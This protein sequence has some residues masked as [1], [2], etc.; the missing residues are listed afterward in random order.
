MICYV[1]MG[2]ACAPFTFVA[3]GFCRSRQVTSGTATVAKLRCCFHPWFASSFVYELFCYI[4]HKLAESLSGA[5][6]ARCICSPICRT[7]PS[8][9]ART[10]PS[11][12]HTESLQTLSSPGA[13]PP[14][15][16][17]VHTGF[18]QNCETSRP[19]KCLKNL[20]RIHRQSPD[21][22]PSARSACRMYQERIPYGA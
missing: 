3:S 7:V 17:S 13:A 9:V 8:T 15:I 21:H 16:R 19:A 1:A 2:R 11:P 5:G 14:R 20:M 18:L 10:P 12:I 4:T 6:S 22:C